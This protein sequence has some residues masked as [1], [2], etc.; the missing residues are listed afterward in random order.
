M[1]LYL[2]NGGGS[3]LIIGA[4]STIVVYTGGIIKGTGSSSEIIKIGGNSVF[5]GTQP[6]V[7]GPMY[8]TAST[9]GFSGFSPLPVRFIGFSV[10]RQNNNAL[11]QW[12]TSE[13]QNASN[14]E[15]ERSE[16]G[17]K[18]NVIGSVNASGNSGTVKDYSYTDKNTF[19]KTVYYRIRQIDIDGKFSFTTVKALKATNSGNEV[20]ISGAAGNVVLQF[21]NEVKSTVTVKV[22]NMN[23]QVITQQTLNQ[24]IGQT[25]LNSNLRGAYLVSITDNQGLN[26]AKQVML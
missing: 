13:E 18:W 15:V 24:P 21:T 6:D 11:I 5:Q 12:S 22:L 9:T 7:E 17:S 20:K 14:Y 25:I 23:G 8:A 1:V 4:G 3:K 19:T 26:A 16:D 10:A 2:V